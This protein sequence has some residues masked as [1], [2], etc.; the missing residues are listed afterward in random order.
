MCRIFDC[1]NVEGF[2]D[3]PEDN[4]E[5]D[6]LKAGC[7]SCRIEKGHTT[8]RAQPKE[9]NEWNQRAGSEV[10]LVMKRL[11]LYVHLRW[12]RG[13]PLQLCEE[14]VVDDGDGRR[15]YEDGDGGRGGVLNPS[16]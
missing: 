15:W 6:G 1:R 4:N 13:Q 3:D 8:A 9:I 12:K 5:F 7:R 10:L 11:S 2:L 16:Y 14:G